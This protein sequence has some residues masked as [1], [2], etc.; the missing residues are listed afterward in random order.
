MSDLARAV[1]RLRVAAS[2][3]LSHYRRGVGAGKATVDVADLGEIL[4]H[5]EAMDDKLRLQHNGG[6]G[7][8]PVVELARDIAHSPA[9]I[10]VF[11]ACEWGELDDDGRTWITAIVQETLR[12]V[13]MDR[14]EKQ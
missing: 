11:A 2:D 10:Q 13:H 5:W 12:R 8:R 1:A 7:I 9:V 4:R 3:P 14:G 6:L